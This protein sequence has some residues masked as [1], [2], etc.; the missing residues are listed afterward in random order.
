MVNQVMI[1]T[2]KAYF[3]WKSVDNILVTCVILLNIIN[4]FFFQVEREKSKKAWQMQ[5]EKKNL[6]RLCQVTLA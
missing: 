6:R 2:F 3:P 5:G 1:E 4:G